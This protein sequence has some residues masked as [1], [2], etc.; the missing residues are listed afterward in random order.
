MVLTFEIPFL[1]ARNE[2]FQIINIDRM[3][4]SSLASVKENSRFTVSTSNEDSA[5][6]FPNEDNMKRV[7][8]VDDDYDTTIFFKTVL[9]DNGFY[10]DTYND[11]MKALSGFKPKFYDLLL[12]D[13]R[14]PVLDGFELHRRIRK[15]DTG[16]K[17]CFMTAFDTY[18]KAIQEEHPTLNARCFMKKPIEVNNFLSIVRDMLSADE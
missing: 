16:V 6:T 5:L 11:P 10:V 2:C 8:V 3:I 7:M 1:G 18:Y 15:K 12:I 4:L 14:M 9:E 17:V 13:I